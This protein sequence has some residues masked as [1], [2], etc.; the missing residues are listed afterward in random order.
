[1]SS[2]QEGQI[3]P[4][5]TASSTEGVISISKFKGHPVVLYFYPRDDTPGCT[6]QACGFRDAW[7]AFQ[8]A[9]AVVLGVSTDT[10]EAHQKFKE[11]YKLPF[12][13]VADEEKKIVELYGVWGEKSF[14]GKKYM[15]IHRTTFLLDRDGK[16]ARVWKKVKPAGH[17]QEV[18]EAVRK[19]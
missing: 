3:A 15:G 5:F 14:L 8:K 17:A 10:L 19:H 9:G 12:T 4:E 18:L 1:M 16:I 2:L 6:K 7:I 13:L 11:K